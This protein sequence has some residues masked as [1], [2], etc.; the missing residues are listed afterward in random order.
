MNLLKKLSVACVAIG[1]FAGALDVAAQ[2]RMPA[3]PPG[4]FYGGVSMLDRGNAKPGVDFSSV[5]SA[6]LKYGSAVADDNASQALVYGGYRFANDVAIE[7][8]MTRSDITALPSSRPGMGLALAS[9]ADPQARRWNADIYSSYKVGPAFA[10]YGRVG[11]KQTE[12]L[13]AYLLLASNGGV[14]SRQGVNYGVGLRYDMT[15]TLGLKLEFAR[16]GRFAAEAFSGAPA[17]SDQVQI[18]VQYRF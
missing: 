7:A 9:L 11:Y 2:D 5:A 13:P 1:A 15:P 17:E 16:F 8:S 4:G 14:P 18:G 12:S 3:P 10:L 6:W